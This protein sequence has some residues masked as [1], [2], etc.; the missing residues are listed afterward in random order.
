MHGSDGTY[1][2]CT[3]ELHNTDI[4]ETGPKK[5]KL[6]RAQATMCEEISHPLCSY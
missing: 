6:T 4:R 1:A 3:V 5:D 2:E